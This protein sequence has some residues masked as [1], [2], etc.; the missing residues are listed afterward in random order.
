M[1]GAGAAASTAVGAAFARQ[2][3]QTPA[4]YP[5]RSSLPAMPERRFELGLASYTLRKF[6]LDQTIAMTTR[7][8]LKNISLKDFHLPMNAGTGE[9]K[10]VAE[11]VRTAGLNLYGC[12]VVYMR[13]EQEVNRAFEYAKAAGMTTIIGV[14]NHDLLPL[15]DKKV[16]EYN[17]LMAIHNHGPG[18]K[19]YPTSASIYE[20]IKDFDARIGM[21]MDI[22]HTARIGEDPVLDTIRFAERVLDVHVKDVSAAEARGTTVQIGRG[23]IDLPAFIRALVS[24]DFAGYVSLE[25]EKD[26]NDPL[27]GLA[28]S[29]GFVRGAMATIANPGFARPTQSPP[30]SAP[31]R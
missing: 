9:I 2:P 18:D 7:V 12:G 8:G 16:K 20:K 14:P 28:E 11:K 13:N 21:C 26:E 31:A 4:S 6:N 24:I 19:L 27:P 1:A 10:A 15:V 17:I 23:V 22:G 29:V 5:D 30:K 3:A 25:Y